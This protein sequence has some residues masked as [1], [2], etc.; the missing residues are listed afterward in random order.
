MTTLTLCGR[1]RSGEIKLPENIPE[2]MTLQYIINCTANP[3]VQKSWKPKEGDWYFCGNVSNFSQI[4]SLEEYRA[5]KPG[6]HDSSIK[7]Y[8]PPNGRWPCDIYIPDKNSLENILKT[9]LVNNTTSKS[10]S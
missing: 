4:T 7:D 9:P 3:D 8:V 6:I 1:I 5:Q 2:Y 10:S